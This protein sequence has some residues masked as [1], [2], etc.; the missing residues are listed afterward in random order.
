MITR[1]RVLASSG[2][3]VAA[4][5]LPPIQRTGLARRSAER[6]RTRIR[7]FANAQTINILSYTTRSL[8]IMVSGFKKSR[9][10][11]VNLTLH[12]LSHQLL[13]P[14][15]FLLVAPDGRNIIPLSDVDVNNVSNVTLTYDDIPEHDLPADP[16]PASGDEKR[17]TFYGINPN[18]KWALYVCNA[19]AS[20][21]GSLAG[22]WSLEIT[23]VAKSIRKS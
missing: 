6:R 12:G 23:A 7:T 4:A 22:G 2:A 18:G 14:V 15:S 3:G 16:P 13:G 11:H 21:P 19:N 8:K 17:S 10:F 5:L 9:R 1:R 20:D